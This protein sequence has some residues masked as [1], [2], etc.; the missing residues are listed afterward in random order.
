MTTIIYEHGYLRIEQAH[1]EIGFAVRG[2]SA[3]NRDAL[4]RAVADITI[5][6]VADIT[7]PPAAPKK[8]ADPGLDELAKRMG[9]TI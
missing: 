9:I 1:N 6:A 5:R 2:L 8:P 4:I 7:P 3:E